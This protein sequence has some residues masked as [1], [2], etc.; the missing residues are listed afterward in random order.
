MEM[1]NEII[2]TMQK[3]QINYEIHE[4]RAYLERIYLREMQGEKNCDIEL[5]IFSLRTEIR[6]LREL[7]KKYYHAP[8]KCEF[9]HRAHCKLCL[10]DA[11]IA[12]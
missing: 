12:G 10:N 6:I 7:R 5:T 1:G 11:V 4:R 3:K 2:T 8:A 9:H